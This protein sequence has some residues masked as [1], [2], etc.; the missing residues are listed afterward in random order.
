MRLVDEKPDNEKGWGGGDRRGRERSG[1]VVSG[2]GA[3]KDAEDMVLKVQR[4]STSGQ[5]C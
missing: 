1:Q 2:T 3:D 4:G 5:M